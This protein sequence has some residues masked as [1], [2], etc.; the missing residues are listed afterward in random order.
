MKLH[1]K[2]FP[3]IQ[4][5][6]YFV[7]LSIVLV[8]VSILLVMFKGLNYGTDFKGGIKLQY[9][10]DSDVTEE[11]LRILLDSASLGEA[12][13]QRIGK[14][15]E[16]RFS[17]KFPLQV[18]ISLEEFSNKVEGFLKQKIPAG[19]LVLE[20]EE[21]VG[22]KAGKDL[23]KKAQLALIV[24]WLL[25]LIYIGYRF[26]FYFAPGAIVAL[27]HDVLVTVG[28]IALTG[29]EFTLTTVAVLLTIIGYSVNDTIVI[30][31]RVR[32]NLSKH[33]K[34]LLAD[35]V[36]LS[37]NETLSRSIITSLTVFFVVVI[38]YLFGKGEIEGFGFVMMIGV[39]AGSYSTI[40]V[41]SPVYLYLHKIVPRLEAWWAQ[42]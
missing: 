38:M 34:M 27:I 39:I 28:V 9:R 29:R 7:T 3:F 31:D 8:T 35:L 2:S 19:K 12:S 4:Y 18:G 32:E 20:Q 24:A 6:A 37:V 10:I 1:L 11:D 13:I 21:I 26:D 36:N 42:K 17:L 30:Y 41:A 16:K 15:D 33:P 23:R 5:Q 25:I 22:P 14:I 40:F